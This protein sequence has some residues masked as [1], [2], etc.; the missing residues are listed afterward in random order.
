MSFANGM[1]GGMIPTGLYIDA[2]NFSISLTHSLLVVDSSGTWKFTPNASFTHQG[3]VRS[4]FENKVKD[5]IE[6]LTIGLV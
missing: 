2:K 4:N 3:V 1:G 6:F 5:S